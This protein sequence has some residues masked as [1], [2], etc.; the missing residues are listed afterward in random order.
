MISKKVVLHFPSKLIDKPII[1][2]LVRDYNLEFNIMKAFITPEEEGL[3]VLEISGKER[4]FDKG[5]KYLSKAGVKIQPLSKDIKRNDSRCTSCGVCITIC[6]T[7]ALIYDKV[8][9]KVHFYDT[10]CIACELCIKACPLR[11]M[12]VH[13]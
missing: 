8:T 1:S 12:S 9:H 10:K 13:F 2:A 3:M 11:A 4:N 7:R 6:P 5:I